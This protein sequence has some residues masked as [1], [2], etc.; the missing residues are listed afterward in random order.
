MNTKPNN[1]PGCFGALLSLFGDNRKNHKNVSQDTK[2][3]EVENLPTDDSVTDPF[4]YRVR[5][6]FLSPAEKSFYQLLNKMMAPHFTVFTKVSLADIFFVVRPNDNRS[7]YNRINRKH[8]D[9][10]ICDPQT[11]SPLFAIELDDRSHERADRIER[12]EFVDEVF[13]A[14]NLPLLHIPL[15]TSYNT[16]ELGALFKKALQQRQVDTNGG[17]VSPKESVVPNCP[18]CGVP[19]MVRTARNGNQPGRKFYGCVNYPRCRVVLPCNNQ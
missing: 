1:A 19:M 9:F 13:S 11:I 10:L 15:R 7:A 5:D 4:P 12:D 14:A 2:D 18:K 17:A 6:D 3:I 8:V 16:S